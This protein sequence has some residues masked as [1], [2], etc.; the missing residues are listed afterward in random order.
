[1]T[2][3]SQKPCRARFL[4]CTICCHLYLQLRLSDQD[5]ACT[6][7]S[8]SRAK[9]PAQLIPSI[10]SSSPSSSL[11]YFKSELIWNYV[12]Y[13]Q[14][15]GLL[16]RGISP[17]SRPLAAQDNKSIEESRTSMPSV[18][19]EPTIPV[20]ERAKIFRT[21]Y[22]AAIVIGPF[23]FIVIMMMMMMITTT[24]TYLRSARL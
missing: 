1:M 23:D 21:L 14:S 6:P 7:L 22:R 18:G 3:C 9:R 4:K 13:R 24:E 11:A 17:V 2:L 20:F 16:G 12:S 19:F 8:H 10:S 5:A 15:A